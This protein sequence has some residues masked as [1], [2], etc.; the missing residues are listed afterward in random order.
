MKESALKGITFS[1][2]VARWTRASE[3][4]RIDWREVGVGEGLRF[5]VRQDV[6]LQLSYAGQRGVEGAEMDVHAR[7]G[8]AVVYCGE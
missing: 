5:G 7:R 8:M 3:E 2:E 1:D 4:R 6:S